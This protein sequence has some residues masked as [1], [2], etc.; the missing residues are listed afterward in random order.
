[1]LIKNKL[2]ERAFYFNKILSKWILH[3]TNNNIESINEKKLLF[4]SRMILFIHDNWQEIIKYYPEQS[5]CEPS[6]ATYSALSRK[7][8]L[9]LQTGII[10]DFPKPRFFNITGYFRFLISSI[11]TTYILI[12]AIMVERN[13]ITT[14]KKISEFFNIK[15]LRNYDDL[16]FSG[17]YVCVKRKSAR[18]KL[19]LFLTDN[20]VGFD[21]EIL[22]RII[23]SSFVE[24]LPIYEKISSK[25]RIT[26]IHTWVMD[27]NLCPILLI[28]C[29]FNKD[30]KIIGYQH[31]G[32]YGYYLDEWKEAEMSFYDHFR[33][34]G[35]SEETIHPFRFTNKNNKK[36]YSFYPNQKAT[37]NINF[38]LDCYLGN[39]NFFYDFK[40]IN[41]I[42]TK[43][44][45][46]GKNL[47]IV[48]HPNDYKFTRGKFNKF[49]KNTKLYISSNEIRFDK[50][51]IYFVSIYSTLFWK[52]I[53]KKLCFICYKQSQLIYLTKY[54]FKLSNLME[55]NKL[56]YKF[57][58]FSSLL[59]KD[60]LNEI[61]SNNENFYKEIEKL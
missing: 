6:Y 46:M 61:I 34:W 28:Y 59:S 9:T 23:P 5:K 10:Y 38:F 56:I 55:K 47:N 22:T 42:S 39:H 19:K 3:Y 8:M 14:N 43:L 52:I 27:I 54:H 4:S 18:R 51:A 15:W 53:D 32:G 29:L 12:K 50:N 45:L 41:K 24:L 37:K 26:E 57:N 17:I 30:I 2:D 33:Y 35:Y 49:T 44:D 21:I 36:Y 13:I 58:N 48:L 20:I 1:M 7:L 11:K 25:L 31:G 16:I 40:D 60:F